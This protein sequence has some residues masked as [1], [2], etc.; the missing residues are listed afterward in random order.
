MAT[1]KTNTDLEQSKTLSKILPFE[2]ADMYWIKGD[3][4]TPKIY[5]KDMMKNSVSVSVPCWS[6]AALLRII[7]ETIGYTL[8]GVDVNNVYMSCTLG[9]KPW[10]LETELYDNEVDVCYEL[11]IRLH[12]QKLL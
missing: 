9:D 3:T 12:E 7:R 2:S 6:L 1:I 8:F 5:P 10:E 11:I 4:E